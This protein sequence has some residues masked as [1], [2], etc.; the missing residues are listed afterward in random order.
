MTLLPALSDVREQLAAL[1]FPGFISRTGPERLT[2]LP[3]YLKA[4]EARLEKL[5]TSVAQDRVAQTEVHRAIER[6]TAAG[7]R[8]PLPPHSPEPPGARAVVARGVAGEP[9]RASD[10]HRGAREPAAHREGAGRRTAVSVR[11]PGGAPGR[12]PRGAIAPG[13]TPRYVR[14]PA[15]L[16]R[17]RTSDTRG[18]CT[19]HRTCARCPRYVRARRACGSGRARAGAR[20][21]G[22]GRVAPLVRARSRMRC[23]RL[24]RGPVRVE[25][26]LHQFPRIE[27]PAHGQRNADDECRRSCGNTDHAHHQRGAGLFRGGKH[28]ERS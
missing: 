12:T 4:I 6:F 18:C 1:I 2:H 8:M 22:C 21:Q 7:G 20:S 14:A 25:S 9:V 19:P 11:G 10:P 5:P 15:A 26:R 28:G 17:A 13:R 23:S 24:A 16:P 27:I 3:R